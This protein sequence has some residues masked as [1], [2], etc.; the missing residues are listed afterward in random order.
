MALDGVNPEVQVRRVVDVL[1]EAENGK[2]DGLDE[3]HFEGCTKLVLKTVCG[4]C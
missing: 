3:E 4:Y 1:P 2:K